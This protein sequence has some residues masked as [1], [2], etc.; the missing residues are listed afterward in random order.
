[1]PNKKIITQCDRV[2]ILEGDISDVDFEIPDKE[3]AD[4]ICIRKAYIFPTGQCTST[5]EYHN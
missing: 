2:V 3:G 4:I 5:Y 1:M